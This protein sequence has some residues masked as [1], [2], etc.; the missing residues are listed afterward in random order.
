MFPTCTFPGSRS[1]LTPGWLS[2]SQ[3]PASLSSS[4][5][6]KEDSAFAFH[7]TSAPDSTASR[8]HMLL[9]IPI[10]VTAL[11]NVRKCVVSA[12]ISSW[13]MAP[14]REHAGDF[15]LSPPCHVPCPQVPSSPAVPQHHLPPLQTSPSVLGFRPPTH[16]PPGCVSSHLTFGKR[17]HFFLRE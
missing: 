2:G 8:G 1:D 4:H 15:L 12:S 3:V 13:P 16:L 17:S 9:Y 14:P 5:L 6:R 11:W 10:D 7:R